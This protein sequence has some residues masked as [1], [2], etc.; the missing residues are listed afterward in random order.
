MDIVQSQ[1]GKHHLLHNGYRY[2]K[3]KV[4]RDGSSTW[5]CAQTGCKGRV[6]LVDD[7][8]EETKDHDHASVTDKNEALKVVAGMRQRAEM[9]V[10]KPRQI[11]QAT[12]NGLSLEIAS[13]LPSFCA[14]Q[15]TIQRKRKL[16]DVPYGNPATRADIDIPPGLWSTS[17]GQMFLL[18]DS[19][20]HKYT[21]KLY[22]HV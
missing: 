2:R 11:I 13:Q 20:K 9:G 4:N 18:W 3:D 6:R 8:V 12:T 15:R 5:R 22:I 7:T 17:R 16:N 19:G 21:H 14:S 10:E 1:K